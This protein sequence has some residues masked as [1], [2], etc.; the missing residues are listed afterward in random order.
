MGTALVV[1]RLGLAAV[2]L[3]AGF[4]KLLDL[5]GSRRALVDFG[6]PERF[7]QAGAVALPSAELA[8]VVGLVIRPSAVWAGVA[9]LLLLLAFVVGI[10]RALSQGRT[11]DCHC[12]GQIHSSPAGR[13]TLVRNALLAAVAAFIA[14][15]GPGPAIDGWTSAGD[16]HPFVLVGMG[17]AAVAV[18]LLAREAGRRREERERLAETQAAGLDIGE[19]APSFVV[20]DLSGGEVTLDNLTAEGKPVLLV[21]THEGC[22]PCAAL[23][24][25]L[26][27]WQVALADKLTVAVVG[28]GDIDNH[29]KFESDHGF[30]RL[31]LQN[32][33]EVFDRYGMT[34]TPAAVL[35]SSDGR[36]DG[37]SVFGGA[38]VQQLVRLAI[39]RIDRAATTGEALSPIRSRQLAGAVVSPIQA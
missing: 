36:I 6:V 39:R 20:S 10:S 33:M 13:S 32:E 34:A 7:V 1:L 9:G 19:I 16:G 27:R 23:M 5:A 30:R 38:A 15:A 29:L 12:F 24:P 25:E 37:A 26:A 3:V 35:V 14:V 2:F 17:V 31:L 11:P 22:G 21:F 18:L 28:G 4:G 8:V